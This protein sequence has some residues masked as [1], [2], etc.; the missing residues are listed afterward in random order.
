MTRSSKRSSNASSL[1]IPPFLKRDKNGLLPVCKKRRGAPA[2]RCS[3][4][5]S[6]DFAKQDLTGWTEDALYASLNYPELTVLDRQ[7]IYKELRR[8]EDK[9]KAQERIRKMKEK[10]GTNG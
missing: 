7:P 1:D 2:P 10:K 3:S 4:P 6:L 8:R 5:G 9:L